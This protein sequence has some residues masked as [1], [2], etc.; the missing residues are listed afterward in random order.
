[1]DCE[2]KFGYKI[3]TEWEASLKFRYSTG[4]PYT[5]YTSNGTQNTRDYNTLRFP[6]NHSLDIRVDKLWFFSGWS[7]I[8]YIDIQNIYNRKN[9]T[10]VRW[11]VRTQA[12]ELNEAIGIL[13]SIGVSAVF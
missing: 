10:S 5:P 12:P 8:T 4:R 6:E 9:I 13:P 3:N 7:L 11:D 1:M 2:F